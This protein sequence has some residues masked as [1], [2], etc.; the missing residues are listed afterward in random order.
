MGIRR[1]KDGRRLDHQRVV[2]GGYEKCR[3]E[4]LSHLGHGLDLD[5]DDL[6]DFDL[7]DLLDLDD[8]DYLHYSAEGLHNGGRRGRCDG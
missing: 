7:L 3:D 2:H 8:L 5:L 4:S 1:Q 6:G